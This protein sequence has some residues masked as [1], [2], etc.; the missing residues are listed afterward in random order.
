MKREIDDIPLPGNSAEASASGKTV[1]ENAK[2]IIDSPRFCLADTD[3]NG[4][5]CEGKRENQKKC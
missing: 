2:D 1:R 3:C 4:G 5:K